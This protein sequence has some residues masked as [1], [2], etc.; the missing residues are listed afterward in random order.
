MFSRSRNK[1]LIY[2]YNA[3]QPKD[4]DYAL[5]F[6]GILV[7]AVFQSTL[8]Q[9]LQR[10]HKPLEMC[11]IQFYSN[12]STQEFSHEMLPENQSHTESA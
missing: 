6:V 7:A 9:R 4:D 1:D 5:P 2:S 11:K 10:T 8:T 3:G 12:R